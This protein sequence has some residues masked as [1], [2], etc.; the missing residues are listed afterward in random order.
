MILQP[1]QL[2]VIR[3]QQETVKAPGLGCLPSLCDISK[4][5]DFDICSL[6]PKCLCNADMIGSTLEQS[7]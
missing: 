4:G 5:W 1:G 6:L 7:P 2:P 3:V